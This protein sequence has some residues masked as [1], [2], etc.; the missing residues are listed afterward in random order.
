MKRLLFI[1]LLGLTACTM[2]VDES[3][4][5]SQQ[6]SSAIIA[7]EKV[8]AE[9]LIGQSTVYI[10]TPGGTFCTG[11]LL[12]NHVVLTAA[13]CVNRYDNGAEISVFVPSAQTNCLS[14]A[15]S[16]VSLAPKIFAKDHEAPDLA[17]LKLK[18]K[19]CFEPAVTLAE[20]LKAQDVVFAAGFGAGTQLG[21]PDSFALSV[22]TS[23][24]GS[25]RDLYFKGTQGESVVTDSWK[26]L[27][28]YLDGYFETSLLA[29][30]QNPRQSLC[31]GDSGGPVYQESKNVLKIFGVNS[32]G[33]PHPTKGVRACF[34]T[35]LQIITPVGPSTPWIESVLQSW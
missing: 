16:D 21:L 11:V 3:Y 20:V 4:I 35:Y 1:S 33:I 29:L 19:F 7:G 27:E 26:N 24:K 13:H 15:V 18:D 23:D 6:N 12:N 28:P 25:L 10:R 5:R 31:Q 32:G 2:D 22:L 14:S 8:S 30:A 9:S 34:N 17:L